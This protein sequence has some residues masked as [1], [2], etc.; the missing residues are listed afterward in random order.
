MTNCFQIYFLNN[1][2]YKMS[3][4]INDDN[5][6]QL[7]KNYITNKS[8]LPTNLANV[9]IG[10][11]DVIQVT[12][13]TEL[14][15]N[16]NDFN[17]PLNNWKVSNV[18][19]MSGM[20]ADCTNF[21]QELN[22][23]TVSQVEDMQSMFYNCETFNQPLNAWNVSNVE[24]MGNMFSGCTNF[25]QPLNSWIVSNVTNMMGMFEQ[26]ENFNQPLND[27][28]V[29]NVRNMI[30][31]FNTCIEFNQ[32]LNNWN[33]SN[34]RNMK[35]MFESCE[36]FNQPLTNWNV[37]NVTNIE[38]MFR[39]CDMLEANK[40]GRARVVAPVAPVAIAFEIHN[41][42]D[43]YIHKCISIISP[44][45]NEDSYFLNF[46]DIVNTFV[47][48]NLNTFINS[49]NFTGNKEIILPKLEAIL[50]K[51]NLTEI[52]DEKKLVI[53]KSMDFVLKQSPEF[54]NF[55]IASFVQDCYHAYP[56]ADGLGISCVKGIYERFPMLIGP[57]ALAMCP[58]ISSCN[59]D[60]YIELIEAFELGKRIDFNELLQEWGNKINANPINLDGVSDKK[61]LIKSNLIN[62]IKEKYAEIGTPITEE[63]IITK[64]VPY[65]YVF[66]AY[67]SNPTEIA[68][69]G[70]K[71]ARKQSNKTTH[72][73][74]NK[75]KTIHKHKNKT[76]NKNKNK[77]THKHKNK[78]KNK[79]KNKN[80]TTHK[81]KIKTTQK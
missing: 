81:H 71:H 25:N 72:K 57:A 33:V 6:K 50:T 67:I 12:N 60:V 64:I 58:E 63:E 29:S 41:A 3:V 2:I 62:F 9:L 17:E 69:G 22:S 76:K 34:V 23:W 10:D 59:N 26:C 70:F 1:Y 7:V 54:I 42:S 13:M 4:I 27:W 47:K 53:G 80:K 75:N 30:R 77:T 19:N 24:N 38:S 14:F 74:K 61:E 45:V 5:I 43:K 28:N 65:D 40:P 73:H 79:N 49:D 32:P 15:S 55:Y 36:E 39:D 48:Q 51:L 44:L 18:T 78:T 52:T 16:F 66:D 31:M 35:K 21:N 68:F 11:W 20:F 8:A 46:Q 56:A 37:S